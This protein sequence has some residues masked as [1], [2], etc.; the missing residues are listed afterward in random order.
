MTEGAGFTHNSAAHGSTVG[1]QAEAVHNS[2]VYIV[3]PEASPEDKYKVGLRFLENGVP[4]RARDLITEAIA[5]G[6]RNAEV[7]CHWVL[8]MLSK[9]AFHDLDTEE[10]NQLHQASREV[11][12]YAD[13]VWKTALQVV[14]DLLAA[15]GDGDADGANESV[16]KRLQDLPLSQRDLIIH[17]LDLVLTGGMKDSLWARTR[18][19]AETHRHSNDRSRRVWAYFEPVPIGPR[20]ELPQANDAHGARDRIGALV[21]VFVVTTGFLWIPVVIAQPVAAVVKLLVALGAGLAA[22][23]FGRQWWYR[24]HRLKAKDE[25]LSWCAN[26]PLSAGE[27]FTNRVHLSFSYYFGT[28]LPAGCDAQQWLAHTAGIRNSLVAE[29]AFLYRESRISVGRVDWLIRHLAEDVRDRYNNGT[30]FAY[31]QQYRTSAET[32][33]ICVIALTVLGIIAVDAVIAALGNSPNLLLSLLAVFGAAW[34]GRRAT[35]LWLHMDSEERRFAE[36]L[37]EHEERL[38]A[39]QVEYQCWKTYLDAMRPTETEME[40]WLTCDKTLFVDEVLRHYQL[41][42]RDIITHTILMT[43]AH[44]YRRAREKGGPWR[45][46]RYHLRLFLVTRD[47]VREVNAEFD[48]ADS[49]RTNE[50]RSN[51]RFDA[52]S[53]VQVTERDNVGYDLELILSNGPPRK[54]RVKDADTH[55]LAPDENAQQLTNINLDAAGFAHAFR[56]LEGIAADGKGWVERNNPNDPPDFTAPD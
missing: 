1:I 11:G 25:H 54:I 12:S 19:L 46:S 48:L 21:A 39:R 6:H 16:L 24:E 55:Q 5:N 42:W 41:S 26:N 8:A 52:L 38:S 7:R 2:N 43:P 33:A 45:Y 37:R 15:L 34:S 9:R 53:S 49:T 51:Y 18:G 31:R 17:H 22:A 28:R 10:R 3:P 44:P 32:K 27:G 35:S 56:L 47:G 20:S 23:H 40:T 36:E 4:S 50:Q 13:G 29:I 30:L 14:F